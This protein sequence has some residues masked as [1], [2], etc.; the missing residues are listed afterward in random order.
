MGIE[1]ILSVIAG[2]AAT[3]GSAYLALRGRRKESIDQ[4]AEWV[5]RLAMEELKAENIELKR[6]NAHLIEQ[7]RRSSLAY[8]EA[9]G[10]WLWSDGVTPPSLLDDNNP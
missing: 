7:L 5:I 9:T 1:A 2:T 8:F 3:L 10:T 4:R 6:D